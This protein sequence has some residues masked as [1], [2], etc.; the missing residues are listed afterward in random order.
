VA[1]LYTVLSSL[2][3]QVS[4]VTQGLVS[5]SPD[6][7]GLALTVQVGLYWPSAKSLQNNVRPGNAPGGLGPTALVTIY[8]RGIAADSTRWLPSVVS[9]MITPPA[10]TSTLSA[11]F[12]PPYGTVTLTIGGPLTLGDAVS[13]IVTP[14]PF[15]SCAV[16][17]SVVAGDT[18]TT[19]AAKMAA[20]VNSNADLGTNIIASLISA[21][22]SGPVVT[23]TSLVNRDLALASYVGNG[24]TNLTEIGRRKRH[25][26]IVVWCRTPDDRITVGDPIELL[27]AELE[28]NFGLTFPDGTLGRLTFSGDV[29]HDEATLSDVLRRDFM[30]C[31]EYGINVPDYVYSILAPITQL[32][33]L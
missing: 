27:I 23:I 16:I 24:G 10:I 6:T 26:Q 31:V 2:Q 14:Q 15:G 11:L 1:T 22:S 25:F 20:L 28:A 33:I 9:Q 21:T 19:M 12:I 18:T 13:L 30:V 3:Q 4:S 32:S 8:D 17:P 5:N 7:F 29:S